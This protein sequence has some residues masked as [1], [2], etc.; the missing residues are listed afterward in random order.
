MSAAN[1]TWQQKAII[2][3]SV[4]HRHDCFSSETVSGSAAGQ[5]AA[6]LMKG[7]GEKTVLRKSKTLSV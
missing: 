4:Q 1:F 5:S 2:P 7:L 6:K 3:F